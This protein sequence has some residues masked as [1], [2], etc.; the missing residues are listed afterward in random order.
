MGYYYYQRVLLQ[1]VSLI[2]LNIF[3][4]AV[5]AVCSNAGHYHDTSQV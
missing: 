1:W 4:K 5:R 2:K 3:I